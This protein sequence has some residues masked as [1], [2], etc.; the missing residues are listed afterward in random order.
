METPD[1][2]DEKY[3]KKYLKYKK[4]Y[5]ELKNNMQM[6]GAKKASKKASKKSSKKSSKSG[7]HRGG[8][9]VFMALLKL[10][11]HVAKTYGI[12][13]GVPPMKVASKI[14]RKIREDHPNMAPEEALK[15][16]MKEFDSNPDKYKKDAGL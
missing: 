11:A 7:S 5:G 8:N 14:M 15:H 12:P 4:L 6:G 9:P 1:L 3:L 10:K 13:N 16:A 2:Q